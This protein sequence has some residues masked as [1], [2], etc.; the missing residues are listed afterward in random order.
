M[1]KVI[2]LKRGLTNFKIGE[3]LSFFEEMRA[4]KLN[5]LAEEENRKEIKDINLEDMYHDHIKID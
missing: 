4:R 1:L 5:A 2:R 3:I